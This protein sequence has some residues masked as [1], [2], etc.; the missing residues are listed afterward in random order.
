MLDRLIKYILIFLL[1]FTPIAFGSMEIWAFSIME[2]GILVMIAL[3][4]IPGLTNSS[5]SVRIPQSVCPQSSVLSPQSELTLPSRSELRTP[6]SELNPSSH[7]ELRTPNSELNPSSHSELRTPN[8]ELTTIPMLLVGLFLVLVFFQIWPFSTEIVKAISPNTFRLRQALA[9]SDS[10]FSGL[11]GNPQLSFVPFATEIEVFKWATLAALFFF[12]LRWRS[13]EN[14]SGVTSQL[15]CVIMLVGVAESLYGMIEFFSGHRYILYL[16]MSSSMS[17]VTGTFI[18]RNYFAGYLLLVIP[19]TTGFLFSRQAPRMSSKGWRYRLSDLDGKSLLIGYS[20]IVMIIGLFFSASRMG[21]IS[22]LLSFTMITLLFRDPEKR[23]AFSRTLA[24]IATLSIVW[25]ATIGLDAVISRFFTASEGFQDRWAIWVDTFRLLKDFPL[26]GSGLG[27]FA[28]VFPVYQSIH[29][30]GFFTHAENDFL[31]LASEVGLLGIILVG[32][33][34]FYLFFKGVWGIRSLSRRDPRRYIGVG[35]LVG[36]LA[37][38][39][40]STVERNIQVPANAFLFTFL[41]AT[42]IWIGSSGKRDRVMG[43]E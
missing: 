13:S 2:I 18:N 22:L 27:T 28:Q 8:S 19:L 24:L 30:Q 4:V 17:S 42:V 20:I 14:K 29:N 36:T 32:I 26:F 16:N 1:I 31:Q 38:L 43:S 40:H 34:F 33:V 11:S 23:E 6:N 12:V 7:S 35:S 5:S 37:L 25:A 15:I 39:F 41:L 9:I 3:A 10:Q 21:I